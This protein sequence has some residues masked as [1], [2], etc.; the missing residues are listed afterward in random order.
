MEVRRRTVLRL[1]NF[2]GQPLT[3]REIVEATVAFANGADLEIDGLVAERGGKTGEAKVRELLLIAGVAPKDVEDHLRRLHVEVHKRLSVIIH[4]GRKALSLWY[5]DQQ[6]ESVVPV[7]PVM[8]TSP[9]GA[10]F[11]LHYAFSSYWDLVVLG[12]LLLADPERPHSE[13][14]FQCQLKSCG[15]L[16][17]EKRPHTGR[18][19]RKYCSRP[20][21]LQAHD[22]NATKRMAKRA[23]V[24]RSK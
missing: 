14:L 10:S 8:R 4:S 7:K 15:T 9:K 13:K 6:F 18:P 2:P 5:A 17:F 20:H 3:E 21:M 16:F 23:A 11:A 19:Q 22:E 24:K 1:K 12:Q